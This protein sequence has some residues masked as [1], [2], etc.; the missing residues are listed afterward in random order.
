MRDC[1]V[2]GLGMISFIWGL[3]IGFSFLTKKESIGRDVLN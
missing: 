1:T 3:F 2:I